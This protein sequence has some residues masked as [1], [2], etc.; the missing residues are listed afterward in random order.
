MHP[1]DNATTPATTSE[2]AII[3][4]PPERGASYPPIHDDSNHSVAEAGGG[5]GRGGDRAIAAAA[6]L[7]R[8]RGPDRGGG[9]A[10][11]L[12]ARGGEA[13]RGPGPLPLLRSPGPRK[14][15]AGAHHR[16]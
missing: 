13:A 10:E 1:A 4:R 9:E 6:H 14:D 5:S 11:G 16:R 12:R 15:V 7:R 3:G 8:V 2:R